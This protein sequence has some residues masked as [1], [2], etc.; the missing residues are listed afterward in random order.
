MVHHY[1]TKYRM[2]DTG[3]L[4]VISWLQVELFGICWCFSE[5][6]IEVQDG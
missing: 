6:E 2:P 5:R 1:I 3:K 4:H